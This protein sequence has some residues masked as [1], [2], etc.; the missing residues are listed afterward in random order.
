MVN[1]ASEQIGGI[2]V[3]GAT[4]KP[5]DYVLIRLTFANGDPVTVNVPV[6]L[7]D[8]PTPR[9]RRSRRSQRR[10]RLV[11]GSPSG[12]RGVAV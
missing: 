12:R 8:G 9:S 4:V 2:P 11:V 5:G 6:V 7:D 1:L 10:R 3:T